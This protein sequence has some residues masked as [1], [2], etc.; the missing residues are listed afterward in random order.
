MAISFASQSIAALKTLLKS[1]IPFYIFSIRSYLISNFHAKHD[2]Y[3]F[4]LGYLLKTQNK[5]L[6]LI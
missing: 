4:L 1:L 2:S 5:P 6:F 3:I